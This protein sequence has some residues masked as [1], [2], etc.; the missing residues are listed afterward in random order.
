MKKTALFTAALAVLFL[1]ANAQNKHVER[2]SG[3][4]EKVAEGP[5]LVDGVP[6]VILGTIETD[7]AS[8]EKILAYP[9]LIS[10][11]LGCEIKGY[12]FSISG[13]GKSWGPVDVKGAVLNEDIKDQV[14]EMDAPKMKVT[15]D[16]IKVVYNGKEVMARPIVIEY[17]H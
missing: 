1:Q 11:E 12:T 9:R 15:I 13:G 3:A 10:L 4:V 6:R 8:R 16:N 17:S 7:N 2:E 5:G 14:K